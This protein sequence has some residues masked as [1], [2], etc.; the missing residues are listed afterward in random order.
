MHR[1]RETHAVYSLATYRL[2]L[3]IC[4][5]SKINH[6]NCI[7]IKGKLNTLIHMFVYRVLIKKT[8]DEIA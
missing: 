7:P 3:A 4:V 8:L 6:K 5:L 1:N 2:G